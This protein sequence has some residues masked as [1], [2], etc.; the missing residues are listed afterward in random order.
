MKNIKNTLLLIVT[1]NRLSKLKKLIESLDLAYNN[2]FNLLIIDNYSNDGT[3]EYL[4]EISDKKRYKFFIYRTDKNLGGSGGFNL[5][6]QKAIEIGFEWLYVGDDDAYP[7]VDFFVKSSNII[8]TFPEVKVICSAVYNQNGIDLNHRRDYK[9]SLMNFK[10]HSVPLTVYKLQK[11]KIRIFSFVGTLINKNVIANVGLPL[12]DYF[13]WWDDTEYSIRVS[14]KFDIYLFPELKVYHDTIE[15][16]AI[17]WKLY[18]G[19]RNR[20]NTIRIHFPSSTKIFE[21]MKMIFLIFKF[22]IKKD[23]LRSRIIRTSLRDYKRKTLGVHKI[24]K[25]GWK[26]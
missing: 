5:G 7:F 3:Y 22:T 16:N 15:D 13:L 2:D 19:I 4:H 20:L 6:F 18:Y 25:P 23:F 12:K 21:E 24:Y 11:S 17:S 14:K 8:N 1:Y 10:D 26:P 9:L